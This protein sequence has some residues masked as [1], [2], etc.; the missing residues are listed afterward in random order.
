MVTDTEC[1][2]R[3]SEARKA[4]AIVDFPAPEGADMTKHTPLRFIFAGQS[5]P[6]S[7]M[8]PSMLPSMLPRYATVLRF[9]SCPFMPEAA[10]LRH[11]PQHDAED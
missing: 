2:S 1:R 3:V 9:R 6:F 10:M 7:T 4:L 5:A 11:S 8:P